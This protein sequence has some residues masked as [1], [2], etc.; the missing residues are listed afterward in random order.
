MTG[1]G[2]AY[3]PVSTLPAPLD[4]VLCNFPEHLNLQNPGIKSRPGLV[5][6][7]AISEP[8]FKGEV[9]VVYG[10]S[11]LKR[12]KRPYDLFVT[13]YQEMYEAG[14]HKATRFDLDQILWLPWA[15]EFFVT[16]NMR[17]YQSPVMGHLPENSTRLLGH[18]LEERRRRMQRDAD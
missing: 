4:I 18:L 5:V 17:H 9:R 6:Q 15:A 11:V 14:L 10:T 16:P 3:Y 8:G 13:N 1:G 2:W 7:T 12:D